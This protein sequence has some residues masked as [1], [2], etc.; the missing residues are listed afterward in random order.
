VETLLAKFRGTFEGQ[1][2]KHRIFNLGDKIAEYLYED[3]VLLG[4]SPKIIA[5]VAAT[6]VVV[7]TLNRVTGK[8]GRRGD[9]TFGWRVP[10][11]IPQIEDGY[12]VRRGPVAEMQIGAEVKIIATK[13]LAQIDRVITDL[14]NQAITFRD[15]NPEAIRVGII[16]VN[17]ADAYTGYEGTRSFDAKSPPSREAPEVVRRV[18][19]DVAPHYDEMLILR[20]KA[21][22]RSP[23]PFSWVGEQETR[24]LYSSALVRISSL[25]ERRS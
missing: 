6:D 19:R 23:F 7:N 18:V 3:L 5:R 22:N 12:S 24:D 16:G 9:G 17:F 1:L 20:Y 15:H 8:V 2:Y 25:Y 4:R 21:T 14:K 13:M 11:A 10:S